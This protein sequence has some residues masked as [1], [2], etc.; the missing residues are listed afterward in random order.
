M[1][2]RSMAEIPDAMSGE[3]ALGVLAKQHAGKLRALLQDHLK[4]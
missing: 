4:V 2:L 1:Q 3:D